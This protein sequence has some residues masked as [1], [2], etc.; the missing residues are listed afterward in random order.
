MS[1]RYGYTSQLYHRTMKEKETLKKASED[2]GS[3][4][5]YIR[6]LVERDL[7]LEGER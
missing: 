5:N 6:F 3:V 7:R 4:S 2:Y 1:K